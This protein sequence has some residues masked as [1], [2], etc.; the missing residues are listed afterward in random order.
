MTRVCHLAK[1][2][3]PFRG[4]IE[5]HVQSLANAQQKSGMDVTV[6]CIN[7]LDKTGQDVWS[8]M[9]AR[10]AKTE[11]EESGVKVKKF[12]KF[13]SFARF[14]FC[15]GLVQF[16]KQAHL[17]F[18]LLHLHVPNP[19]F[20]VAL[21]LA[22]PKV[23]LVVTYHSDI[24]KQKIARLPFRLVENCVF[25]R[26]SKFI[27]ATQE[28]ARS[29]TVLKPYLSRVEIIP[30]GLNLQPYQVPSKKAIEFRDRLLASSKGLPLW[31]CVGRMVYYKGF[32]FA[33]K[34]LA[35]C[36]GKLMFVGN[37]PLKTNLERLASDLAVTDRIEWHDGLSD[38]ELVGAYHAA[39]ALWFPS[40]MRSE[41]FGLVQ[42]EA[43]ACGCPVIN[44]NIKGSGVPA[45]S[46]HGESGFTIAVANDPELANV[47]N[48]LVSDP[49]LREL[50]SQGAKTRAS[51]EFSLEAMLSCTNAA[52]KSVFC[53]GTSKSA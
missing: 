42:V 41:A 9:F 13:A 2:Y 52:Y 51:R 22:S 44:T 30:F 8:S 45:V 4:G 31:L 33:V 43:M 32:E 27:V 48:R 46:K 21:A 47:A 15:S 24:V 19:V 49:T 18:D 50:F 25:P 20:S 7:H 6:A 23:P 35:K 1:Y 26:V 16:L 29:S 36:Q 28:Y 17:N 10:T 53:G 12:G 34:A 11:S 39:T 14:D 40:I 3:S 5:T 37:G 38:D